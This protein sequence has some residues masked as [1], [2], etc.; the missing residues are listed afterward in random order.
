MI[1]EGKWHTGDADLRVYSEDG[2]AICSLDVYKIP[3]QQAQD[4]AQA[5]SMVPDMI[6]ALQAC[7]LLLDANEDL[8]DTYPA[9]VTRAALEKAGI[10][11]EHMKDRGS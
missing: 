3:V 7:L 4:N 11:G 9:E 8:R 2:H 6:E 1:T 5:I 10:N